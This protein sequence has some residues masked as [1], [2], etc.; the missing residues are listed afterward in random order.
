MPQTG[1]TNQ[2]SGIYRSSGCAHPVER[3]IPK[4]HE[5]PPCAHCCEGDVDPR[6]RGSDQVT[7]NGHFG[8]A[9][10]GRAAL[11]ETLGPLGQFR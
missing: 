7:A 2:V 6:S 11:N 9:P 8:P 5:F 4:G 10:I 1:Q 3:S